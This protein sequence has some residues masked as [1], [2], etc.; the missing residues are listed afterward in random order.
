MLDEIVFPFYATSHFFFYNKIYSHSNLHII[1]P[2]NIICVQ[3][4]PCTG[5]TWPNET[6]F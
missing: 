5:S 3:C 2:Q 4:E 1:A 6:F